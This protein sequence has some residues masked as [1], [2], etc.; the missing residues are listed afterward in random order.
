MVV[1]PQG[2]QNPA[3]SPTQAAPRGAA[4]LWPQAA[5]PPVVMGAPGT[6]R[7]PGWGLD[8]A[9]MTEAF[10]HL[11]V[12][13]DQV[14]ELLAPAPGARLLDLTAGGG[15][16]G[17]LLLE[18]AGPGATYVGLD[19]DPAALAAAKKRLAPWGEAVH[20]IRSNFRHLDQ[21]GLGHFDA[22]LLDAGVSSPQLDRA[23]RGFSFMRE[24]PLDMRMD[25][26]A[27]RTAADFLARASEV[28]LA[29][30]FHFYGEE[31]HARRLARAWVAER[32]QQAQALASTTAFAAWVAGHLPRSKEPI[33]PAT[34]VFQ[35][36]RIEVNDELG[37]LKAVLPAA[38]DSLKPG[39]RFAVISFHSLE[40]RL[41]KEAFRDAAG[42]CHCPPRL[43][44]C[45]C[46]ATA[47]VK[48]LTGK[49]RM[50]EEAEARCNPR[51]RSAKVRACERLESSS[52]PAGGQE[53]QP[54]CI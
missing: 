28:E 36:L 22:I 10:H 17:A 14:L 53:G 48:V 42:R 49:P 32:P 12:L 43:P 11:P 23:E 5:C 9:T 6:D 21:L 13:P 20:L 30:C 37:A 1:T 44:I 45:V 7:G 27:P 41:V 29:D 51:A 2:A 38:I 24:G 40:D 3:Y 39:G 16:H 47:K 34:R 26:E 4:F 25:P 46:G 54:A 8:W 33:H 35:A 15:G 52:G 31:R 18:A 19:Q 50:A